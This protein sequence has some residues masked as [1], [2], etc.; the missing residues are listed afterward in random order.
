MIE[1]IL[2]K[3][4]EWSY[5]IYDWERTSP[6][7]GAIVFCLHIVLVTLAVFIF[8]GF[9]AILFGPVCGVWVL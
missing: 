2:D 9:V 8:L 7:R 4:D 5:R 3:I 1:K 6:S